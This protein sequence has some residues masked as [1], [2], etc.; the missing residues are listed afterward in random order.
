MLLAVLRKC[1]LN[2][3]Y[4][5]PSDWP[6]CD[7]SDVTNTG[8]RILQSSVFK[9]WHRKVWTSTVT[10]VSSRTYRLWHIRNAVLVKYLT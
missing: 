4:V 5:K 7:D 1:D 10:D 6:Q 3:H 2:G 9:T 8:R